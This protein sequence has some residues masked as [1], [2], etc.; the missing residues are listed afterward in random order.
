MKIK[1]L[2][3]LICIFA[4]TAIGAYEY[5]TFEVPTNT[6]EEVTNLDLE[7]P[8]LPACCYVTWTRTTDPQGNQKCDNGGST[9]CSSCCSTGLCVPGESD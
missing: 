4:Y 9:H 2:T 3:F 1:L 8:C 7:D 5:I 6:L